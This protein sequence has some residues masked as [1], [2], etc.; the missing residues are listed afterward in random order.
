MKNLASFNT[1]APKPPQYNPFA[2]ALAETEREV[3]DVTPSHATLNPFSEALAKTGNSMSQVMETPNQADL[4]AEQKEQLL[5]EQEKQLLRKK[6]HDQVNPTERKEVFVQAELRT[7]K[8]LEAVRQ[9]LAFLAVDIKNFRQEVSMAVSQRIV[10]PGQTGTYYFNFFHWLRITIQKF[11]LEIQSMRNHIK[12]S[13][14][15]KQ[16]AHGKQQK[17]GLDFVNQE[18]KSVHDTMHHERQTAYAGG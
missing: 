1:S 16:S 15:W 5:A 13:S 11:R 4:L 2:S 14:T 7:E 6:L 18:S 10:N 12:H 9:E 17:R 8:E 3:R